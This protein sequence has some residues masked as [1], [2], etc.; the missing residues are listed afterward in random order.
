MFLTASTSPTSRNLVLPLFVATGLLPRMIND[1][2]GVSYAITGTILILLCIAW[3]SHFKQGRFSLLGQLFLALFLHTTTTALIFGEHSPDGLKRVF[4]IASYT[5]IIFLLPPLIKETKTWVKFHI[6]ISIIGCTYLI[7]CMLYNPI[8]VN[9]ITNPMFDRYQGISGINYTA[10]VAT[11]TTISSFISSQITGK[12]LYILPILFSTT[13]LISTGSR[14]SMLV[15]IAF[16]AITKI[17]KS[18][19]KYLSFLAIAILFITAHL[20][21]NT[22]ILTLL[23]FDDYSVAGRLT[24][25]TYALDSIINNNGLPFGY[26]SLNTEARQ[27]LLDNSYLMLTL[28]GGLPAILIIITAIGSTI[29]NS[30]KKPAQTTT[31]FKARALC[32]SSIAAI[33]IHGLFE[34]YIWFGFD[35]GTITLLFNLAF[36]SKTQDAQTRQA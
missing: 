30:A 2:I 4:V 6:F 18:P 16:F 14:A 31:E 5:L 19:R 28:E 23:R 11:I 35:I 9:N 17:Q 27:E 33:S 15:L 36:L 12:R 20:S 10:I 3:L 29:W 34:T 13:I 1:T 21:Q 7:A 22:E 26:A 24:G 25:V 8:T 32:I